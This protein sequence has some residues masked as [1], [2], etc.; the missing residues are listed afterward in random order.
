MVKVGV[1]ELLP[2]AEEALATAAARSLRVG[3]LDMGGGGH[4][5]LKD[6]R[7]VGA[8]GHNEWK[9]ELVSALRQEGSRH[10]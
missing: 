8:V 4:V 10:E 6:C 5:Q 1:D 2:A 3:R 9:V 7:G